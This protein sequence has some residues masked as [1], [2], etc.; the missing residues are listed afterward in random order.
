LDGLFV[1]HWTIPRLNLLLHIWESIDDGCIQVVVCGE[2]IAID[3]LLIVQE[4]G[5]SVE[6]AVDVANVFVKEAQIVFKNI[7]GLD[8]FANKE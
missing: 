3:Q 8:A 1:V 6:G 7:V 2:K 4:I 5:V